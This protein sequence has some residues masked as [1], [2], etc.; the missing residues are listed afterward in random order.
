MV[1]QHRAIPILCFCLT[2][3]GVAAAASL[4]DVGTWS[5]VAW[6]ATFYE[7]VYDLPSSVYGPLLAGIIPVSGIVGGVGGGLLGDRL[8]KAGARKVL[9]GG[10]TIA[11]GPVLAASLLAPTYE[12][13]F[14]LLLVGLMLSEVW[15]SNAAVMVRS[16]SEPEVRST[17]TAVWL[18]TRNVVAAA[19]PLSVAAL[20]GSFGLR[21]AML[22]AP[23][24]FVASGLAFLWT[25]NEL[26]RNPRPPS[27]EA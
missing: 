18:T 13:S 8:S 25:E 22:L 2:T 10:A 23:A 4:V 26:E 19:G 17:A 1:A 11:A 5:L 20:A 27:T 21:H 6:Q 3:Q 16:I 24:A 14:A 15:R 7:R 12:A 9:T